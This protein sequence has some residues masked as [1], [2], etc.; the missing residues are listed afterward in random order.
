MRWFKE[1]GPE[2]DI[3]YENTRWTTADSLVGL[4][5]AFGAYAPLA[6]LSWAVLALLR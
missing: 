4:A 2:A 3:P 5:V 6:L 1:V